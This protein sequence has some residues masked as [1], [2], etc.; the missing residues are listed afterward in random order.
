MGDYRI[1]S[2]QEGNAFKKGR[3]FIKNAPSGSEG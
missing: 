3:V 1:N 2:Q